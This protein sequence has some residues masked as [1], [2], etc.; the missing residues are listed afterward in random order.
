MSLLLDVFA[1]GVSL[2]LAALGLLWALRRQSGAVRGIVAAGAVVAMLL[3][4][5]AVLFAPK[6]AV[7]ISV[8]EN[9]SPMART[10]P[11]TP[12]ASP[13]AETP[14][15]AVPL[16]PASPDPEV[17]ILRA[18]LAGVALLLLR[19]GVGAFR[20]AALARRARPLD[21]YGKVRV[22]G[23][24]AVPLALWCGRAVVLLPES[25]AGWSEER[26]RAVLLHEAAHV[27][28][29]DLLVLFLARLGVALHWPNPLAWRLATEAR[30]AMEDAADEAVLRAGMPASA[31]A[32]HLLALAEA[33]PTPSLAL[34]T[35]RR[36]DLSR[37]LKTMLE[38]PLVHRSRGATALVA[39]LSLAALSGAALAAFTLLPAQKNPR[40]WAPDVRDGRSVAGTPANGFVGTLADGRKVTVEKICRWNGGTPECWRPDG[41]RLAASAAKGV[42]FGRKEP[43]SRTFVTTFATDSKLAQGW[44][45]SGPYEPGGPKQLV[46]AGGCAEVKGG[47]CT[48]STLIEVP[49]EDG[50]FESLT[51][52]GPMGALSGSARSRRGRASSRRTR[53][54]SGLR[55][56]F[57]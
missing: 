25:H 2:S 33:A 44:F 14:A 40:S 30:Q 31:Y 49:G 36:P 51:F 7:P 10:E 1:R 3:S 43:H 15:G 27:R 8:P 21:G 38:T 50:P 32:G 46:F 16:G 57:P 54:S 9:V 22:S 29:G 37:R 52:G 13:S 34:S 53:R 11:A 17:W 28:R 47:V 39:V 19:L 23:E 26:R 6:L 35:A 56:N 18:Y 48:S 24:I 4:P 55:S 41:T 20:A 12:G 42:W 45:G 5:L